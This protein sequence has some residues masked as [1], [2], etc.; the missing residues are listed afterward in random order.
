MWNFVQYLEVAYGVEIVLHFFTTY[1]DPE[2]FV[3]VSNIKQ[4][5][6]HY[7]L[8]GTFLLDLLAFFPFQVFF[9]DYATNED[10]A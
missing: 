5:A 1:K 2:T 6:Q 3:T 4:I 10:D 8:N 7:I 9:Y